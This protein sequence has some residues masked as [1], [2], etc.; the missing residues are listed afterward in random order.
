MK[1]AFLK[2]LPVIYR[3]LMWLFVGLIAAAFL[4][5]GLHLLLPLSP[6]L[7]DP[8]RAELPEFHR[9]VLLFVLC[10]LGVYVSRLVVAA[11]DSLVD[12]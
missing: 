3:E 6:A 11:V 2:A 8:L 5:S 9:Q 7:D 1:E 4:A 12:A 10:L